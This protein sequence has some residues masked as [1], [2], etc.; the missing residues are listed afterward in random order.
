MER[1]V[2]EPMYSSRGFKYLDPTPSTYGGHVAVYES[3]A[4]SGPHLW[5]AV[6]QDRE[7]RLD[8]RDTEATAHLTLEAATRL[9]DQLTY[10]IENHYQVSDQR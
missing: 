1:A 7:A 5:V 8:G 3:S 10:L 4:A 6:K 9:R 2:S